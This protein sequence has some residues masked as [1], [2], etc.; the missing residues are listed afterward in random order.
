MV[1][2]NNALTKS[3]GENLTMPDN[4]P[5]TN[6]LPKLLLLDEERLLDIHASPDDVQ[7]IPTGWRARSE[8]GVVFYRDNELTPV[9][10]WLTEHGYMDTGDG[11]HY[12]RQE[13]S[14][15]ES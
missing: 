6:D 15:K 5:D 7:Y 11:V 9:E 2:K 10:Q 13:G 3:P 8:D 4:V 12:Q 14:K 1:G